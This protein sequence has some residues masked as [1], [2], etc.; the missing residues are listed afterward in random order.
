[1]FDEEAPTAKQ[2]EAPATEEGVEPS[3]ASGAY[4][5]LF[6]PDRTYGSVEDA[7]VRTETDEERL[8]RQ[9]RTAD[10]ADAAIKRAGRAEMN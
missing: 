2:Q 4:D 7:A 6:S 1:M 9:R 8:T 3:G 10:E 5:D